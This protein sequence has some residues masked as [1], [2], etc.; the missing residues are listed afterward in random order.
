MKSTKNSKRNTNMKFNTFKWSK[1]KSKK[2][3]LKL[4]R[5]SLF[6]KRKDKP[7]YN[8]FRN[9]SMKTKSSNKI[10]TKSKINSPLEVTS[11]HKPKLSPMNNHQKSPWMLNVMKSVLN[12]FLK[13]TVDWKRLLFYW[14]KPREENKFLLKPNLN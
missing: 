3:S 11:M 5:K 1:G 13:R 12:L 10:L 6:T 2:N 8:S 4:K 14:T 7:T 9:Y